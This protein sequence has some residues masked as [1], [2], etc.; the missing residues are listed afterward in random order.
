[1][2]GGFILGSAVIR[3]AGTDTGQEQALIALHFSSAA[4]ELHSLERSNDFLNQ[5]LWEW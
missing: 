4:G 2:P 1:M 3:K 5:L